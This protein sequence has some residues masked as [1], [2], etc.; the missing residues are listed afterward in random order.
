MEL[1]MHYLKNSH[2]LE[3]SPTLSNPSSEQLS[4]K[5]LTWICKKILHLPVFPSSV[6]SVLTWS[7]WDT[8][9]VL[10]RGHLVL[11]HWQPLTL[12][13][14]EVWCQLAYWAPHCVHTHTH[15]YMLKASCW[16]GARAL[17]D[18]LYQY[19]ISHQTLSKEGISL[20]SGRTRQDPAGKE[21]E[22][23]SSLSEVLLCI[24]WGGFALV[25][26]IIHQTSG[27]WIR[28]SD[29]PRW[30]DGVKKLLQLACPGL[31]LSFI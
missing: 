17:G 19:L 29:I 24:H 5:D 28:Q 18:S 14:C 15:I 7:S 25:T 1:C 31:R 23:P 26:Y 3:S 11:L 30:D 20:Q 27:G 16:R 9:P 12:S 4:T 8:G 2:K 22:D 6:W 10:G 13:L 21:P